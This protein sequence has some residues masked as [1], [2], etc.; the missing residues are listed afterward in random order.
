MC[1][2]NERGEV[3]E[4]RVS[5]S[6]WLMTTVLVS[7]IATALGCSEKAV[8]ATKKD[9]GAALDATKTGVDKAIDATKTAGDKT[10]DVSKDVA[11]TT[12]DKTANV[13]SR[14]ADKTKAIASETAAAVTD[15]WIT[16]KLKAKFADETELKGSDVNVDTTDH[17]VTLRGTVLSG[18]A[19]TRAGTIARGTDGVTRVINRIVVK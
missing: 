15:G 18:E 13:A 6:R 1:H 16:T 4:A 2:E 10:A 7:V 17:V 11:L 8:D 5:F 14:V 19:K 3:A 9:V 12:A